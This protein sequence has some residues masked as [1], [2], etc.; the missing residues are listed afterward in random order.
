MKGI[1]W[2]PEGGWS[3]RLNSHLGRPPSS[4]LLDVTAFRQKVDSDSESAKVKSHRV[5]THS[6]NF[7]LFVSPNA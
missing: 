2:F 5:R 6:Q 4:S 1:S 7:E 3:S